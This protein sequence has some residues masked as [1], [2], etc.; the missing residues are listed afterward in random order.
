M[1]LCDNNLSQ[2]LIEKIEKYKCG[3]KQNEI[4]RILI[5]LNKAFYIMNANKIIHKDIKLENILIKYNDKKHKN[6]TIKLSD[7]GC[8][9]RL[10]SLSKNFFNSF[11]GTI[12]YMAPEISKGKKYNYKC[13]LWSIEILIYKL[14]FCNVPFFGDI[15]IA[16][17]KYIE[18]FGNSKLK[19]SECNDLGDLIRHLLEKDEEKRFNWTQYF[20]HPFFKRN[21]IN[22]IKKEKNYFKNELNNYIKNK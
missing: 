6:F 1:E 13:D 21:T 15:E 3:L 12:T 4:Y 16:L 11:I 10:N 7:Y 8:S 2:L 14:Y 20:N 18:K 9:K 5:Q 19:K 17:I 22:K